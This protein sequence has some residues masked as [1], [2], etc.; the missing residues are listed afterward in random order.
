MTEQF[1]PRLRQDRRSQAR[2]SAWKAPSFDD[3]LG[4]LFFSRQNRQILLFCLGF[5]FP[6]GKPSLLATCIIPTSAHHT[7]RLTAWMIASFLPLPPDPEK[8]HEPTPTPSQADLERQLARD[9]GPVD[10]RSFQKA[11]WWRN[12]N[13]IMAAVGT[14]LIG[15]IVSLFS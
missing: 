14:L 2:L 3:S 5:I 8:M 6:I 13:R 4:T 7:E 9:V 15:V 12:L 10:D 1:T 11:I